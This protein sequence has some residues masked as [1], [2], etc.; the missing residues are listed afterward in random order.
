MVK[1]T[2]LGSDVLNSDGSVFE[3]LNIVN[4]V[5]EDAP[6][7]EDLKIVE[8]TPF[9]EEEKSSVVQVEKN[10]KIL[11]YEEQIRGYLNTCMKALSDY[12]RISNANYDPDTFP[13]YDIATERMIQFARNREAANLMGL[14]EKFAPS[15]EKA[16]D[17][18]KEA[19]NELVEAMNHLISANEYLIAMIR[20]EFKTLPESS[21]LELI[22]NYERFSDAATTSINDAI[23]MYKD[24]GFSFE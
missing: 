3:G 11:L 17:M 21:Q 5:D 6:P 8:Q 20:P 16:P 18:Y 7:Q 15:V 10:E 2:I 13:D 9:I 14:D 1:H 19:N 22:S 4:E 24:N 23:L 12:V